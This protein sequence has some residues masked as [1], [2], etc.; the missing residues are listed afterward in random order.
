MKIA[1]E[2]GADFVA[3][4]HYC[5]KETLDVDGKPIHRLLAGKDPNKDQSYFLCQLSQ[6]QLVK[7]LFPLGE[8]LKPKVREIAAEQDLS[9]INSVDKD[10]FSD[11]LKDIKPELQ[12]TVLKMYSNPV[13]NKINR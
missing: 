11:H 4:G 1:L 3:T 2:L 6:E 8:L 12:E 10:A 5:R 13:H 9:A 7:T